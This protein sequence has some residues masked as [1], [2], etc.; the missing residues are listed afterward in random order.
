MFESA[1]A[2]LDA[3]GFADCLD[4]HQDSHLFVLGDFVKI[5][6][7]DLVGQDMVL[8]VLDQR[9]PLGLGIAGHREVH[10]NNLGSGPMD[11]RF[12][13]LKFDFQPLRRVVASVNHGRHAARR[14]QFAGAGPAAH[15]PRKCI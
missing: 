1:A 14:A 8:N 11:R 2:G 3:E 5:N 15:C 9:Q 7:E 4:G 6:V 12:D 10:Q 13:V